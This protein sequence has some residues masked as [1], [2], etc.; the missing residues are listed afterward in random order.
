V[1]THDFNLF[2]ETHFDPIGD[3]TPAYE[4][5]LNLP[6]LELGAGAAY[7]R[8]L[9]YR[10]SLT[11][12]NDERNL[13]IEVPE[14]TARGFAYYKG[15]FLGAPSIVRDDPMSYRVLSR[16]TQRGVKLMG[17]A[18][19]DFGGLIPEAFRS[20]EDLRVYAEAAVLGLEDQPY[21]YEDVL[22]RIPV[23]F[24]MNLPTLRVLDLLAVQA[25]YYNAQF[26]NIAIYHRGS[27]PVWAVANFQTL[28]SDSYSPARWRWSV[29]G[30][31]S[32]NRLLSVQIQVASD[33]LRLRNVLSTPTDYEVTADPGKWYYLVRMEVGL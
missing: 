1:L 28:D 21:F 32:L 9:S 8:G 33:H 7:N 19:F 10:P 12:P 31:R 30:K 14:D 17:R 6:W 5:G 2:A 23:M 4:I 20:P 13:Y 27:V 18:A 22:R 25:E 26:N 3:L 16:W 24:G 29:L 11:R 15:P